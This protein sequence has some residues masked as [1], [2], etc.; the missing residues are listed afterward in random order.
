MNSTKNIFLASLKEDSYSIFATSKRFVGLPNEA[1]PRPAFELF[2]LPSEVAPLDAARSP[3][4]SA[5]SRNLSYCVS[6]TA[7]KRKKGYPANRV[8]L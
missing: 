7:R 8:T 6:D 5:A 1:K 4:V 3:T 2:A